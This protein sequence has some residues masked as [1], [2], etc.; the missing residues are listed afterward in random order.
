MK[1]SSEKTVS[2][3]LAAPS[4]ADYVE[5]TKPGITM[6]VL[7]SMAVG[8]LL[9]SAG[10][11]HFVTLFHAVLGTLLIAGGTAAHN[12]YIERDL[13]KLMLRTSKR[14]LP[15]ERI[16]PAHAL[17]FSTSL[18]LIGFAWLVFM[19]NPVAGL[20]SGVTTIL[21]LGAYTPLK[22]ISFANVAVGSIPGALPPV[23]GWAA[24]TGTITD[25]G[26]WVLFGIVFL[27]QIPHV[28]SIAWLCN[29]DYT[30]AG[31]RMLPLRDTDGWISSIVVFVCLILLLP[32]SALLFALEINGLL[33]LAG[34]LGAGLYFTWYGLKFLVTRTRETARKL[35]FSSLFY[36]PLV[37]IFILADWFL[38]S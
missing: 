9:G 4:I 38:A 34:A 6:L 3:S 30:K 18:I 27:W 16:P 12:Q 5:L 14:P 37:W 33:Y 35:M 23:G 13:D 8:F 26:M 32:V 36:L 15:M 17:L 7:A 22:R 10:S 21:Y 24:A 28:V 31:F 2:R 19:V 11:I 1:V 29:E 25:P 20:V